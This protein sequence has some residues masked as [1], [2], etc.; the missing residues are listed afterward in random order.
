VLPAFGV[1]HAPGNGVVPVGV[2]VVVGAVPVVDEGGVPPV[3]D[4]GSVPALFGCAPPRI[5]VLQALTATARLKQR[6][7][8]WPITR[9]APFNVGTSMVREDTSFSGFEALEFTPNF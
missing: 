4:A 3:P 9:A 8:A 2:V 7:E 5:G 1:L 6:A